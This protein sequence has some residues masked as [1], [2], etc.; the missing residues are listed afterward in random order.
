MNIQDVLDTRELYSRLDNDM[1]LLQ[2]LVEIFVEDYPQLMQSISEAI[3]THNADELRQAAH[4]LKGAVG[5]FC[6]QKAYDLALQ[7]E[8]SGDR[9]DFSNT[10]QLYEALGKELDKVK[11]AL[12]ALTEETVTQ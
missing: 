5:N 9:N 1:E 8:M 10:A 6:A 7:L 11:S 4:T 2:E 3:Q 12:L